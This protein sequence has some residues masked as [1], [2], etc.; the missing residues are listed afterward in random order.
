M[1]IAVSVLLMTVVV[2]NLLSALVE[3]GK[4]L[5]WPTRV[6]KGVSDLIVGEWWVVMIAVPVLT[7]AIGTALRS[8]RGR[9]LWDQAKLATP[10]VG[11]LLV[12]QTIVRLAVVISTLLRSG[13]VFV[14]AIEVARRTAG[15]AVIEEGLAK[16]ES[17]IGAGRD[18]GAA[19]ESTGVFPPVVVQ[20]FAVGQESGKL[21]ELLDRLAADY[22]AQVAAAAQRLTAVLEPLLIL[23]LVVLVG[24]IGFA[25]MMP[26]LEAADGM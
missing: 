3:A 17:A 22:D 1:A 25:T 21:E 23:M 15:N 2:P 13:V 11:P 7:A 14:R 20:V 19:L 12:K 26:L 16:C 5:P 4:P 10:V 8:K 24:F 9:Y 6:V 18:I